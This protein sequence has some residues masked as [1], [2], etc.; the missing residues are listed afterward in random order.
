MSGL[1]K[2][3]MATKFDKDGIISFLARSSRKPLAFSEL[4]SAMGLSQPDARQMKKLLRVLVS[5]GAVVR[6]RR[7][8]YGPAEEL[9]LVPGYFEVH[10]DGYGFVIPEKPGERDVFVPA[11]ATLSAMDNDRVLVRVENE[12]RRS[13]R[14][15]RILDRAHVRIAGTIEITGG[16]AYVRPRMRGIGF[17]VLIP[18]DELGGGRHGDSAI[19]EI[20]SYPSETRGAAGR[21]LKVL[22]PATSPSEDVAAILAEHDL[23]TRF[24]RGV[25][26]AARAL[27]GIDPGER[28]DLRGMRTVTI[29]GETAKDFDDAVSIE[30]GPGGAFTLWVHIADVAH[31]VPW[32]S[33]I[34]IEA[35]GRGTS[36]YYP[37]NVIPMLPR[38]LS[39][40]LCSLRPREDKLAFTAEMKFGPDGARRSARFFPSLIRSDERMTYT[41]V[42]KILVDR[43]EVEMKRHEALLPDFDLM[44]ELAAK[45]REKRMKRGSLDFDLPEPEVLLNIQGAPEN[46]VRAERNVAHELIEDFMIAANEAVAEYLEGRGIPSLYRIHEE[47]DRMKINDAVRIASGGLSRRREYGADELRR[48]LARAKGTP[49]EEVVTYIVLRSLKQARYAVGNVGHFGLASKCYSHFTSPIRRYP[50][51]VVHRILRDALV[52]RAAAGS[53]ISASLP[54]IAFQ[55]SRRERVADEVEREIVNALRVWFM[56]ER[57]GEEFD[58]TIV[59]VTQNGVGV[60]LREYYVDG[61]IHISALRGDYYRFDETSMTLTGR[62]SGAVYKL[63]MPMRVRLERADTVN[64]ELSFG[65]VSLETLAT[66]R[67]SAG[68]ATTP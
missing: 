43:D 62:H 63:G 56:R 47:P 33:V 23:P 38:E 13:G 66:E 32:G 65:P 44:S 18:R 26:A 67:D 46:I 28:E 35:R 54:D 5:E 3:P 45:L 1:G 19:V 8:R 40:D 48:V 53:D 6:D 49:R 9:K 57:V 36:V 20:T 51:L 4:A 2:E 27:R 30:K 37:G 10:A 21:V 34:D 64:R 68:P 25:A 12:R 60:R 11:R 61:F 29:D 14:I 42:R 17:D 55:S 52:G 50:D 31:F 39:E 15:V 59:R 24:P 41:A 16:V 22:E 58:A 7:G